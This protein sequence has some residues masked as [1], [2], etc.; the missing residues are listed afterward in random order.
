ML[1]GGGELPRHP[2][3]LTFADGVMILARHQ[4]HLLF[5][6]MLIVTS[7]SRLVS[8]REP[9]LNCRVKVEVGPGDLRP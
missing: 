4:Q 2:G 5:K 3:A 1:R 6:V 8:T 7:H 9:I